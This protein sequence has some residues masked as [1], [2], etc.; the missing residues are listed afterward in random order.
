MDIGSSTVLNILT[1]DNRVLPTN[2]LFH[3]I[4]LSLMLC[5]VLQCGDIPWYIMTSEH[6]KEPT[7]D[8]FARNHYFGL[9]KENLVVFEQG[10][11]PCFTFDG[12]IIM[13]NPQKVA[14]APDGNGGLY[15]A[16]RVC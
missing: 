7:M 11:L 2:T 15:R 16:L 8:F 10:M 9:E 1:S 3:L 6:T 12:K 4:S 14:R 5:V 13:E